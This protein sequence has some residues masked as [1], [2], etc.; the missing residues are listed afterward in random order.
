MKLYLLKFSLNPAL[1]ILQDLLRIC[2]QM[3]LRKYKAGQICVHRLKIAR[4]VRKKLCE[5]TD[6]K[7]QTFF[8]YTTKVQYCA[9]FRAIWT[10]LLLVLHNLLCT[11]YMLKH[12]K[13][14]LT[15]GIEKRHAMI[16]NSS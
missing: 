5:N 12:S 8:I 15:I 10:F 4:S 13:S 6:W 9:F 2:K 7:I 11:L 1:Y 14:Q 16:L 3:G